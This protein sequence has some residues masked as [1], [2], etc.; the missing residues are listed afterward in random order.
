[1]QREIVFA[2][3]NDF[4]EELKNL[5]IT[6]IAFT[7]I[8]EKRAE[9]VESNL[10]QVVDIIKLELLAYKDSTIYKCVLNDIDFEE[11]HH[12]LESTGFEITRRSRNIT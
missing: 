9:Q 2:K 4:T 12:F 1:M 8:E 6:R 5:N 11:I 10:L 7:E 3:L